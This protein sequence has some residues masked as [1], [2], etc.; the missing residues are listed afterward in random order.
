MNTLEKLYKRYATKK[1][2]SQKISE[3]KLN[4]ILEALTLTP[5]SMG[6]QPWKFILVENPEL[7]A[8]LHKH[9]NNQNQVIDASHLIILCR[10]AEIDHEHVEKYAQSIAEKRNMERSQ[11]DGYVRSSSN[12]LQ[13]MTSEEKGTWMDKQLYIAL[14]NLLTVCAFENVDACPMEGF[15][16]SEYDRELG[17]ASLG[18]KTVLACPIGYRDESDKYASLPKVRFSKEDLVIVK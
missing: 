18:L 11:L 4:V 3:E 5:S 12:L 16:A 13:K 8:K 1:F 9:S 7:R 17:L 15:V 14:G 2:S 6:L 10:L